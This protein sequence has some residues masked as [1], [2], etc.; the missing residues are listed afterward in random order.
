MKI[1]MG[2][3]LMAIALLHTVYALWKYGGPLL[4]I[5]GRGFFN[6][7][8]GDSQ[9]A[10]AT[11]FVLFGAG[12]FILGLAVAALEKRDATDDLKPIGWALLVMV[13]VGV[14]LMPASGFWLAFPPAVVLLL[15]KARPAEALVKSGLA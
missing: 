5:A 6:S 14:V 1:S 8:A 9:R 12:M 10:A 4:D 2:R 3:C 15:R 13:G 11:W 7:I